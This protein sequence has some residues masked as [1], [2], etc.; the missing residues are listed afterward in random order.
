MESLL[1]TPSA[2]RVIKKIVEINPCLSVLEIAEI[3]RGAIEARA[4]ESLLGCADEFL[5]AEIINESK[6]IELARKTV[7]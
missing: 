4:G 7:S 2:G 1:W 3:L 5:G 6:A